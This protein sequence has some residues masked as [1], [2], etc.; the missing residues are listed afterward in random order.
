MKVFFFKYINKVRKKNENAILVILQY[1]KYTIQQEMSSPP[2]I[3]IHGRHPERNTAAGEVGQYSPFLI[4]D[5]VL[6]GRNILTKFERSR[7]NRLL[8]LNIA[9]FRRNTITNYSV[10]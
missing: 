5:T 8:I 9:I 4:S 10:S 3:R 1:K 6:L 7:Y 2:C